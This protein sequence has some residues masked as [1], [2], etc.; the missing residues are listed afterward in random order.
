MKA[1]SKW[2]NA[3]SPT[4]G[5]KLIAGEA[6]VVRHRA[7]GRRGAHPYALSLAGGEEYALLLAVP[8]QKQRRLLAALAKAGSPGAVIGRLEAGSAVRLVEGTAPLPVPGRT[9]FDHLAPVSAPRRRR[10]P[11]S[12]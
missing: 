5:Q 7:D 9:G 8:P 3:T 11:P 6:T 12:R 4:I 10:Q 2:G 1:K